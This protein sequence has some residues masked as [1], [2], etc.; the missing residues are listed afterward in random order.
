MDTLS[1]AGLAPFAASPGEPHVSIFMP[2]HSM[3]TPLEDS[4]RLRRLLE[5]AE[6]R[7][8]RGGLHLL[9]VREM[10]DPAWDLIEDGPFPQSMHQSEGLALFIARNFL[11]YY[12]VP[13]PLDEQV[14]LG[15]RFSI[16]PLLPLLDGIESGDY[17]V[18]A[19]SLNSVRLFR[20]T[21][22]TVREVRLPG[23]VPANLA[24][25]MRFDDLQM[26]NQ[27]SSGMSGWSSGSPG[28]GGAAGKVGT[29]FYGQSSDLDVNRGNILRYFRQID[30]GLQPLLKNERTPLVLAGPVYLQPIYRQANTYS[31]LVGQ[32]IAGDPQEMSA[33]EMRDEAWPVVMP[34]LKRAMRGALSRF[35][36]LAGTGQTCTDISTIVPA[37]FQGQ[38]DTLFLI[39]IE[40]HEGALGE[41]E[42][43]R[44]GKVDVDLLNLAAVHTVLNHGAVYT[45]DQTLVPQGTLVAAILRA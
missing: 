25:S 5:Q 20:A 45:T 10:M 24:E 7:L 31:Y 33:E 23:K 2:T 36:Q 40:R 6:E 35:M 13:I 29:V 42:A 39:R 1:T 19:L 11:R 30:R 38:V 3:V 27:V 41:A 22:R 34:L 43:A 14:V 44:H 4:V 18:L 16:A 37:A 9:V 8:A 12:C 15:D 21:Q 32:G 17:F 26:E 28:A